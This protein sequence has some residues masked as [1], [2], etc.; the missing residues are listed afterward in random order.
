MARTYLWV[1]MTFL[2]ANGLAMAQQAQVSNEPAGVPKPP[3]QDERLQL[4]LSQCVELALRNSYQVRIG[5]AAVEE[6]EAQVQVAKSAKMPRLTTEANYMRIGPPVSFE[7]P[8]PGGPPQQ[9]QVMPNKTWKWS[10]SLI[11]PLYTS[12]LN[13]ARINLARLGVD[14]NRLDWQNRRRQVALTAQEAYFN[15]MKAQALQNVAQQSLDAANEHWRLARAR[16]NAGA[17]AQF[18]V[19]RAEVEVANITQN[20]IDAQNGVELAKAALRNVL[21]LEPDVDIVLEG[22]G[23]T[24]EY[25]GNLPDAI[26]E[27]LRNRPEVQQA[28]TAVKA[29]QTN[30]RVQKASDGVTISLIG[31]YD[32]QKATGLGSDKSWR[33]GLGLSKPLFDGGQA[34]ASTRQAEAALEKTRLAAEQ[35]EDA[36]ELEVTQA[37]LGVNAARQ[38]L[39][40]TQT[41][42]EQAVEGLR[43]AQL[44]YENGV[45]TQ[46]EVLDAQVALTAARTNNVNAQYDYQVALARLWNAMGHETPPQ[47]EAGGAPSEE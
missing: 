43:I 46:V 38:K 13:E 16:F 15:V 37:V 11:Q 39:K 35:V 24:L 36:I 40:T 28:Q 12:G 31:G 20:L 22:P 42:V 3:A 5:G 45:G 34:R 21:A 25:E 2:L 10:F 47:A 27:A 33:V 18:E 4:S 7:V 26:Q 41:T 1:V 14:T 6:A 9:I 32:F 8:V 29:A 19:L 30:V 17:A 44:R 23:E